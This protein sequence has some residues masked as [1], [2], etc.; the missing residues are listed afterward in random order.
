MN[1]FLEI[2]FIFFVGS[3]I[4][5]YFELFFRRIYHGKWV[6]PGF[7]NGP[8]LPIYGFGLLMLT[9]LYVVLGKYNLEPIVIILLMG[10]SMTLIELIAG[11]IFLR[12]GIRLWDYRDMWCNIKGVICPTFSVIWTLFAAIYYYFLSSHLFNAIDWYSNNVSFSYIL[13]IFSG[14]MLLDFAYSTN[15]YLRI[16][17]YARSNNI[18]IMYEKLKLLI[19]D[20]QENAKERYSFV[21][22]F[23]QKTGNLKEYLTDYEDK[24]RK[25]IIKANT[26]K[27]KSNK[28]D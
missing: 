27:K 23:K 13:G 15:L 20:V 5:Y 25:G 3:T 14:I 2:V 26:R 28:K 18:D 16:R 8:Y 17:M 6:N 19:K 12:S 1:L 10:V 11:L 24:Y 21:F 9:M 7:L 22:P 4:G